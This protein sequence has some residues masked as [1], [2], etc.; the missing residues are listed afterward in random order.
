M[1][2]AEE[3]VKEREAFLAAEQVQQE[4]A[5]KTWAEVW[6]AT[7]GDTVTKALVERGAFREALS[8]SAKEAHA[9][10]TLFRNLGYDADYTCNED[11]YSPS[12]EQYDF[13]VRFE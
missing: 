12:L 11:C 2:R 6:V 9:L 1:K 10:M 8:C 13:L 5:A 3:L 7:F 4:D